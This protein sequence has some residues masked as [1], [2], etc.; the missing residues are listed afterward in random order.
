MSIN[1][2][3]IN[4]KINSLRRYSNDLKLVKVKINNIK[5]HVNTNWKADEARYLINSL[6]S[7][8]SELSSITS[9]IDF[10]SSLIKN[11]NDEI[12]AK[13]DAKK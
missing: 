8:I 13:E 11:A 10:L 3:G 4:S 5:S 1:Y 12:K 2:R 6:N 9:N 7:I